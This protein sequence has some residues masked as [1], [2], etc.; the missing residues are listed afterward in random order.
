MRSG[1]PDLFMR[2]CSSI[3]ISCATCCFVEKDSSHEERDR[4]GRKTKERKVESTDREEGEGMLN[5]LSDRGKDLF[6]GRC[7]NMR[8]VGLF[9]RR[10]VEC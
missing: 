9:G 4:E 2:V 10:H 1:K 7:A 8:V 3:K 5:L 6:D